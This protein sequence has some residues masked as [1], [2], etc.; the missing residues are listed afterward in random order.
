[1]HSGDNV[2]TTISTTLHHLHIPGSL[3]KTSQKAQLILGGNRDGASSKAFEEYTAKY[4]LKGKISPVSTQ[5]LPS[6]NK[7]LSTSA[8]RM[9][10]LLAIILKLLALGPVVLLLFK[11]TRRQAAD[12]SV[13]SLGAV[14]TIV[15][16]L[17]LPALSAS[18]NFERVYQ[19]CLMFMGIAGLWALW[20]LIPRHRELKNLV[21]AAFVLLFFIF[22]PGSG[23]ANQFIGDTAPRMN[24]NSLGE[25]YQKYYTHESEVKSAQWLSNNCIG[26]RIFADRYA[27]LRATAYGNIPFDDIHYD[28]LRSDNR[29]C[30][31]LDSANTRDG[32]FYATYEKQ[33]VRYTT[34]AYTFDQYDV[35]YTNGNSKVFSY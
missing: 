17:L 21:V 33:L 9:R 14:L 29:G 7:T 11:H 19:Q 24:M 12:L 31:L 2:S 5:K 28:I 23:L 18:Y 4:N 26:R 34:P 35:L 32:L 25:E 6:H 3:D 22:T 8:D 20:S 30:L 1:T 13:L 15:S 16:M 27:T 10:D